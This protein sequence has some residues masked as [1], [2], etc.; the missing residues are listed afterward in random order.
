MTKV[1]LAGATGYLGGYIL[2]ELI[3]RNYDLRVVVRSPSKLSPE[4]VKK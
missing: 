2:N 1:L 4:E 3:N